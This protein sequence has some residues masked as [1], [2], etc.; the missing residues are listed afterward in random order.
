MG[1]SELKK[2][3]IDSDY[4]L[5][6]YREGSFNYLFDEKSLSETRTIYIRGYGHQIPTPKITLKAKGGKLISLKR[7]AI[8]A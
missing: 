1:M 3:L 6:A 4:N 5:D 2:D 7:D 8:W